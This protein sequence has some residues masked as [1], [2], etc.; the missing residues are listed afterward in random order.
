MHNLQGVSL[1]PK[2]VVI[3]M[4]PGEDVVSGGENLGWSCCR[5]CPVGTSLVGEEISLA[6]GH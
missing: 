3:L 1:P 5:S 6:K 2:F 4:V